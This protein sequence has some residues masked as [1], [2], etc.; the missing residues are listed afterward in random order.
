MKRSEKIVYR[1]MASK[2]FKVSEKDVGIDNFYLKTGLVFGFV[3]INHIIESFLL[4]PETRKAKLWEGES[5]DE[6]GL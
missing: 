4:N 3:V 2:I 1:E 6:I 5:L